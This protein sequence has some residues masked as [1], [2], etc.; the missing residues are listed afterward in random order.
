MTRKVIQEATCT[1]CGES[2]ETHSVTSTETDMFNQRFTY[3]TECR[4]DATGSVTIKE[5]GIVDC[6]GLHFDNASWNKDSDN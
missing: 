5:P 3:Y 4:C 1:Q 6:Q 2:D